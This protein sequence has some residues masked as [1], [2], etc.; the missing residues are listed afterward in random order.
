M[1]IW[2][3]ADTHFGHENI[4]A[5]DSRPWSTVVEMEEG[6]IENWNAVVQPEDTVYHLGDFTM[7]GKYGTL[8]RI[9]GKLNGKIHLIKGNHDK[10]MRQLAHNFENPEE[11]ARPKGDYQLK[12]I[13][14][15]DMDA[16][17]G[18]QQIYLCHFLLES[19]PSSH[20]GAWH[21]HGHAHGRAKERHLRLDVGL[22]AVA[23]KG[24]GW[25]PISYEEIKTHI[26][27]QSYTLR[28]V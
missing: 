4:I 21:L 2:F 10:P 12:R 17:G 13:L 28:S 5:H 3:T 24:F 18:T 16:R 23:G 14:V 20:Y 15:P 22:P 26:A 8:L 7:G 9:L 27:K 19:W 11:V 1:T 25:R 6:I